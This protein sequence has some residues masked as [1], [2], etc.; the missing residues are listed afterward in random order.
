[1]RDIDQVHQVRW[2]QMMSGINKEQTYSLK[3]DWYFIII[4]EQGVNTFKIL[5]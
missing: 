4:L 2:S 5:K 1:M 3:Q